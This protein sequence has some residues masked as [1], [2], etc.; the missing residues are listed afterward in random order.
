MLLKPV[1]DKR[2]RTRKEGSNHS[3]DRRKIQGAEGG[4]K[5]ALEEL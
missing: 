1:E 5:G 4:K 3:S 2:E